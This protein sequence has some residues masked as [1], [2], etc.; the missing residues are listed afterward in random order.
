MVY[1]TYYY[2]Y[3][4][5]D[6]YHPD[7][8]LYVIMWCVESETRI[9]I[10]VFTIRSKW[11]VQRGRII[12]CTPCVGNVW[13]LRPS[14]SII[15]VTIKLTGRRRR[16]RPYYVHNYVS[17]QWFNGLSIPRHEYDYC[18]ALIIDTYVYV[19]T[20]TCLLSLLP[21]IGRVTL[22]RRSTN[23]SFSRVKSRLKLSSFECTKDAFSN[24]VI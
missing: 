17:L 24:H 4:R 19:G 10:Y 3:I 6:H 5:L 11:H 1:Y 18:V 16:R 12:H 9:L 20:Y 8:N 23:A 15:P 7:A 21:F 22:W 13:C 2:Y 14:K